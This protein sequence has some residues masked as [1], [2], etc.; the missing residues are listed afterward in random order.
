MLY[1]T[2]PANFEMKEVYRGALDLF[3][4]MKHFKAHKSAA[5][6]CGAGRGSYLTPLLEEAYRYQYAEEPRYGILIFTMEHKLL[7]MHCIPD[8]YFTWFN[9]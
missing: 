5:E 2:S 4:A 7:E 1:L 9:H 8:K 3:T 6:V